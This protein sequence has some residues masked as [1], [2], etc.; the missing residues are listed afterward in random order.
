M[1]L[2]L[3]VVPIHVHLPQVVRVGLVGRGALLEADCAILLGRFSFVIRCQ[4][5]KSVF[6]SSGDSSIPGDPHP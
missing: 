6:P 3:E 5:I 2:I 4:K 1:S